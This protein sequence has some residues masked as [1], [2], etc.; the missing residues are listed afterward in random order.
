M[1]RRLHPLRSTPF[2]L[3]IV[4]RTISP[5][6]FFATWIVTTSCPFAMRLSCLSERTMNW[7]SQ[8]PTPCRKCLRII[9]CRYRS[10]SHLSAF[11]SVYA[12]TVFENGSDIDTSPPER[13]QPQQSDEVKAERKKEREREV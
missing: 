10:S 1:M 2:P 11:S 3:L 8:W 4:V 6:Y 13:S 9:R 12:R 7:L 5:P